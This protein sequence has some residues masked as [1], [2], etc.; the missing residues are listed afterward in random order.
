MQ[1]SP[2]KTMNQVASAA[3]RPLAMAGAGQR[4]LDCGHLEVL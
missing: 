4:R 3:L 1:E 2:S